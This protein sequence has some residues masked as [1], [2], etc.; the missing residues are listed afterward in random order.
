MI[1]EHLRAQNGPKIVQFQDFFGK[2]NPK[3]L[4][5]VLLHCVKYEEN[6]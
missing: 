5:T 2:A 1:R 3:D 4:T 6:C